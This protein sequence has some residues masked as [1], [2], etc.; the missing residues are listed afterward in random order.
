VGQIRRS[1]GISTKMRI[2]PVTLEAKNK[3]ACGVAENFG[4][5]RIMYKQ[6][7]EKMMRREAWKMFAIPSAIQTS[8]SD[9]KSGGRGGVYV[10][11]RG[12]RA[13]GRR[14]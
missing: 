9:T 12:H 2:T 6:M 4:L 5:G 7:M 10:K 8:P 3:S 13:I 14:C 1:S 11:W